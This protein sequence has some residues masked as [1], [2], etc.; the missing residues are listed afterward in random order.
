MRQ[1]ERTSGVPAEIG[2]AANQVT[3]EAKRTGESVRA[4]A[5]GLVA[6]AKDAGMR[7]AEAGREQVAERLGAMADTMQKASGDMRERDAWLAD[8][9]DRGARELSSFAGTIQ[10]RSLGELVDSLQGFARRQPA[11]YAGASV[12]LGFAAARLA[13]S[14]SARHAEPPM[15]RAATRPAQP[16]TRQ[17][18]ALH[19]TGSSFGYTAAG[20]Q[21]HEGDAR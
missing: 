1:D 13:K 10:Q 5:S 17:D 2:Q 21:R 19:E 20:E 8:L 6:T 14:S 4:E 16:A 7:Q 9:L 12:A 11:L 18:Y 3:E 15:D